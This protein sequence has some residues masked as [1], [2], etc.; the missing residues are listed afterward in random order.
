M[1]ETRIN[2]LSVWL[3]LRIQFVKDKGSTRGGGDGN[4]NWGGDH[5]EIFLKELVLQLSDGESL[6]LVGEVVELGIWGELVYKADEG[7]GHLCADF[8]HFLRLVKA[9]RE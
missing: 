1:F 8:D 6:R 5:M 2:K 7:K 4:A 3:I 9:S